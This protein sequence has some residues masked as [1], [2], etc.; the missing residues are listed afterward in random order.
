RLSRATKDMPSKDELKAYREWQDNQKTA[1]QRNA[2]KVTAAENGRAAAEKRAEAAEAKCAALTKGVRPE[3]LDDVIT[4]AMSKVSD[5][6]TVEQA[7]DEVIKKHP[8]FCAAAEKVPD[9]KPLFLGASGSGNNS[10][11]DDAVR[12]IMGLPPKN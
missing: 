7:I 6:K 11:N 3:V 5:D 2:E 8:S 1:E 12:A 4:L 10:Q 9:K